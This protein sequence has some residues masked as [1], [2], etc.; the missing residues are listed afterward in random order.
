MASA[1]ENWKSSDFCRRKW[2]E[3]RKVFSNEKKKSERQLF[4]KDM[5]K[6]P[7]NSFER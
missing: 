1:R 3:G 2:G 4:T 7:P 5:K 6:K